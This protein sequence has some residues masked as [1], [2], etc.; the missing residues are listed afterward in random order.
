MKINRPIVF[1]DLETTGV[2]VTKDRIVQIACIKIDLDGLAVAKIFNEIGIAFAFAPKFH[3]AMRFAAPV[4]KELGRPTIFNILGPLS[5]PAKPAAYAIGVALPNMVELVADVLARR[6][7]DA[8][9]FRGD[10]GLDEITLA[11]STSVLTI[12]SEEIVS[13]LISPA[14]FGINLSPIESLV[15]GDG[16]ENA[17]ISNE[18]FEGKQ[19]PHRDACVLNAAA[20]IAAYEGHTDLLL[21]DRIA[22]GVKAANLAL[23]SGAAKE[24]VIKWAELTQR[25]SA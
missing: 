5:N 19:G 11:T 16:A 17:R 23:D 13:G 15:G 22:A 20:A 18:I 21:H 24:L 2:S 12:G 8:L 4:R 1:F 14:D 7:V 25:L 9:V 3:S 6:G 10:D